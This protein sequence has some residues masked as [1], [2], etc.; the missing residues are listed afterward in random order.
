[1][2]IPSLPIPNSYWVKPDQFL[3]GEYP[4]NYDTEKA[5][6]RI[7]AFLEAGITDF[8]DLTR[9]GE[10]VPYDDIL[11]EQARAYGKITSYTRISIQDLGVPSRETMTHILDAIDNSVTSGRKVYVHCW[12]GV[13]RTGTIIGCY[14]VRHGMKGD[15]A[16]AQIAEWWKDIPKR[17]THPFSPETEEQREFVRKWYEIPESSHKSKQRFCEG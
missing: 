14:L 4:G 1:M 12:G 11:N 10:L 9:P 13:G 15:Q 5:R 16:L 8:I 3:A 6:K 2:T 17:P 7:D